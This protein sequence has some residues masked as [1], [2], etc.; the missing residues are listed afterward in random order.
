MRPLNEIATDLEALCSYLAEDIT[1]EDLQRHEGLRRIIIA[2][3][4][5]TNRVR[6]NA[7]EWAKLTSPRLCGG[8]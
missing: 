2:A 8:V 7:L 6:Y 5:L 4:D 1:L 3:D